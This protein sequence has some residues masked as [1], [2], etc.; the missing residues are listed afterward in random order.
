MTALL[1]GVP[2]AIELAA[3]R[4]TAFSVGE[5]L[6]LL[7]HDLAGLG[8][9]RRRGP[10]RHRTVRA[11]IEWSMRLLSDDERRLLC[12]LAMLPGSFRLSTAIAVTDTGRGRGPL[13]VAGRA[14]IGRAVVDHRRTPDGPTRYRLL[15]MI[16]SVGT[17]RARVPTSGKASS[18]G[19][20]LTASTR[21][22]GLEGPVAP[23]AGIEERDPRW[24]PPS[25]AS[26]IEHAL[27]TDQIES[28]LRL[29][30]DLFAVVARRDTTLDPRSLDERPRC[31]SRTRRARCER[32]CCAAKRSSPAR[33]SAMTSVRG[34]FSKL[35]KPTPPYSTTVSCWPGFGPTSRLHTG[36]G[37]QSGRFEDRERRLCEAIALLEETGDSYVAETLCLARRLV[38]HDV[39]SSTR[40]KSSSAGPKQ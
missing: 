14:R 29:V 35:R 25:T 18:T 39:A 6:A 11:A 8:D 31:Q 3:A 32:W 13:V 17:G 7:Q 20:S 10:D 26:S 27:A 15:E 23:E 34:N 36:L 9:A 19:C 4:V 2:L 37:P 1:D 16:R 30:Y 24:T 33:I 12:R 21:C 28:G 38:R 22:T 40:R 5:I